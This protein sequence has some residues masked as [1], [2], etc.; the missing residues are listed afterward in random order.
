MDLLVRPGSSSRG[1]DL[2]RVIG[3]LRKNCSGLVEPRN[4]GRRFLPSDICIRSFFNNGC[5]A[6]QGR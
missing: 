2:G 5:F 1:R 3:S 6:V 4:G